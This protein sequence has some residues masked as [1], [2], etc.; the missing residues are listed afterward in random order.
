MVLFGSSTND[1]DPEDLAMAYS[2]SR[3]V[4]SSQSGLA[5]LGKLMESVRQSKAIPDSDG[6][7]PFFGYANGEA[8]EKA[9]IEWMNSSAFP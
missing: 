2:F 9:W 8:L 6:T 3:F 5:G 1:A 4:Q 7:A